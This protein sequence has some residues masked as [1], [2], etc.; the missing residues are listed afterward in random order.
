MCIRDRN[1]EKQEK[2]NTEDDTETLQ[3]P[4]GTL[5]EF[6]AVSYTHLFRTYPGS[7]VPRIRLPVHGWKVIPLSVENSTLT[8]SLGTVS[9]RIVFAAA[10]GP[11]LETVSV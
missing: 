10:D 5:N 11:A 8:R 2:K 7:R 1:L 6:M 4:S 3:D 9:V